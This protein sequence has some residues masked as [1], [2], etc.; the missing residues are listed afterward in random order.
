MRDRE[1]ASQ[2]RLRYAASVET[3][4]ATV[5]RWWVLPLALVAG[6]AVAAACATVTWLV[7]EMSGPVLGLHPV[8]LLAV[9][10]APVVVVLARGSRW[11]GWWIAA[12]WVVVPTVVNPLLWWYGAPA[13][14]WRMGGLGGVLCLWLSL[15]PNGL[16]LGLAAVPLLSALLL[17][18]RRGVRL[19]LLGL[20]VELAV[21]IGWLAVAS[22]LPLYV[23]NLGA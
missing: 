23:G 22:R 16:V 11:P 21:L 3:M 12:A 14:G 7:T 6:V 18:E 20:A 2:R 13:F 8:T 4:H 9:I 5:R 10:A 1:V 15:P 17:R 19:L